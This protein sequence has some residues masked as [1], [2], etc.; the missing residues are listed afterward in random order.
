MKN[1][2]IAE[3]YKVYIYNRGEFAEEIR[4]INKEVTV[5]AYINGKYH[6]P[7]LCSPSYLEELIIGYLFNKEL[8]YSL[9]DIKTLKI[10]EDS[11]S[12][13]VDLKRV[14][15]VSTN[16]IRPSGFGDGVIFESTK[17]NKVSELKTK[18]RMLDLISAQKMKSE[19]EDFYRLCGGIHSAALCEGGDILAFVED[20][21]RHNTFDKICGICLKKNIETKGK[22]I[23]TSGRI[24]CEMINKVIALDVPIIVSLSAATAMA[25]RKAQDA[26]ITLIGYFKCNSCIIYTNP[27]R[28]DLSRATD[29]PMQLSLV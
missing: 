13:Y 9:N 22:Q 5:N 4:F 23:I 26:K 7:F 24:S 17:R 3:Q 19:K 12:I 29:P 8:I 20:I 16:G 27:Y 6:I 25:I 21:G 1:S 2:Q 10:S 18:I 14:H 11:M 15:S 28:V